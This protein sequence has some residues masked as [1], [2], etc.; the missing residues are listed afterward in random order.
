[1]TPTDTP[2]PDDSS[3]TPSSSPVRGYHRASQVVSSVTASLGSLRMAARARWDAPRLRR[4]RRTLT[5]LLD[6]YPPLSPAPE[7]IWPRVALGIVGAMALAFTIF[8]S[9]Y[10]FARHDAYMTHAEDLGIMDQ[11]LWNTLHGAPLH[12]TICDRVTDNNCLGDV[13]RLAI[14]FEPIMFL[15]SLLYLIAPSPKTLQFVQALI[16]AS[17]AFP[18]FWLAMRRLRSPFAGTVFA[19]AYLLFPS[20]QAA[21]TDDF[22]AVTLSA[23]F[24]LFA[25]YFMLSRNNIGLIIACL[26]ALSTKEEIP[27]D[28]ALIGLSIVVLQRRA[29]LGWGLVALSM[30]WLAAELAI[31][32]IASPLGQSPTVARYSQ[33]GGSPGQVALYM[34]THPVQVVRDYVLSPDRIVYLRTLLAPVAYL[35]LVAP[36]T[37]LIAVPALAINMLSSYAPM[38]S[39]IYQYNAEIIPVL[40]VAAIEGVAILAGLGAWATARVRSRLSAQTLRW[41]RWAMRFPLRR[42]LMMGLTLLVLL[43]ALRAQRDHGYT[44]LAKGFTWPVVTAHAQ[45]ANSI[46]ARIPPDASVSAQTD[47]VPHLS[48]RRHIYLFPDLMEDAD[49]V[50]LDVTGSLYPQSLAVQSYID[51][52][53][54][55]LTGGRYH[56]VVADEGYLL[57]AK[58]RGPT[59]DPADRWG[60]PRSFYRFTVTTGSNIPHATDIRF[61]SSLQLVGYDASPAPTLYVNNPYLTVTTY[62]RVEQPLTANDAIEL[63]FIR[64]DGSEFTEDDFATTLWRP[65]TTWRPGETVV[66]R[67]WPLLITSREAGALRLGV[68]V[69]HTP[70]GGIKAPLLAVSGNSSGPAPSLLAGDTVGVFSELQVMG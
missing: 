34:L 47:L 36:L 13:S 62:W 52:A 67:N 4:V 12:Q 3:S 44:S 38:Y 57:L 2:G 21:V 61:G 48:Q 5:R 16:V 23:A 9:A 42:T 6:R 7:G 37:V 46:I 24:L 18:A 49:Y 29:R 68:R 58:G 25:L 8:F 30:V 11:A 50:F 17:G 69:L 1:M 40:I 20:L 32:H 70:P 28:V 64:A 45:L 65:L 43:F 22:H 14:H 39:G 66:V 26:L 41:P 31:M 33:L 15:L 60:L 53:R 51:Q 56:V 55:L 63:V 54:T 19:A 27:L 59:L 10:L 35:P